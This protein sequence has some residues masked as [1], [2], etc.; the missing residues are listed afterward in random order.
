M[1]QYR[2]PLCRDR[3]SILEQAPSGDALCRFC[4]DAQL[5]ASADLFFTPPRILTF[6][7]AG[8]TESGERS[9]DPSTDHEN[10][11]HLDGQLHAPPAY[12]EAFNE[13][14]SPRCCD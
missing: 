1:P 2:C 13:R 11:L 7:D 8:L 9:S 6:T 14:L 12:L 5:A 3:V 10:H 4:C